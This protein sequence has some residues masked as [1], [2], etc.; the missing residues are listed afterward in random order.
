MNKKDIECRKV[1]IENFRNIITP[2]K[3]LQLENQK[4]GKQDGNELILNHNN[5]EGGVVLLIGPNNSGKSNIL[6]AIEYYRA[7][8]KEK[9]PVSHYGHDLTNFYLYKWYEIKNVK[10]NWYHT[11][12]EKAKHVTKVEI[13]NFNSDLYS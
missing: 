10:P 8:I 13:S 5:R 12:E 3:E 1:R 2:T 6:D 4:N 7:N 11:N 9:K